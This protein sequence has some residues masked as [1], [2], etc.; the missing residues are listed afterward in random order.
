MPFPPP[1]ALTAL[2]KLIE[3]KPSPSSNSGSG[4]FAL[5]TLV[6]VEDASSFCAAANRDEILGD[7]SMVAL[8]PQYD[9]TGRTLLDIWDYHRSLTDSPSDSDG[10][11]S[12]FDGDYFIVGIHEN[13]YEHGVLIVAYEPYQDSDN[14]EE[15]VPFVGRCLA[16]KEDQDY[17]DG[18]YEYGLTAVSTLANLQIGNVSMSLLTFSPI[19]GAPHD[20]RQRRRTNCRSKCFAQACTQA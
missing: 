9:F 17:G 7:S 2:A 12:Q 16:E 3:L 18:D 19:I 4:N 8:A 15:G 6:P 13:Y 14:C 11:T 5:Y 20:L 10:G 1:K